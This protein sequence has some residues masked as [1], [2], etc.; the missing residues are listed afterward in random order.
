MA[1][2]K[3][4]RNQHILRFFQKGKKRTLCYLNKTEELTNTYST[5][6]QSK[7]QNVVAERKFN[8]VWFFDMKMI[9]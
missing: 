9:L 8:P 1:Y 2:Q 6:I 4:H 5:I 7:L 3:Y